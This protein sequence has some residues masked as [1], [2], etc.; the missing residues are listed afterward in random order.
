MGCYQCNKSRANIIRI[1]LEDY[2]MP[3]TKQELQDAINEYKRVIND[4]SSDSGTIAS[5]KK[6]IL[7]LEEELKGFDSSWGSAAVPVVRTREDFD[8]LKQKALEGNPVIQCQVADICADYS[9]SDFYD[10]AEAAHWYEKAAAQGN[11]RAQWLLGLF[12]FQGL[13]GLRQDNEKAEEWLLKSAHSGD[14]DGQYALG[15][16]YSMKPDLVKAEYWLEKAVDG[17]N[18]EARV[19]LDGVRLLL[20]T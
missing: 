16:F 2:K 19:M 8:A 7:I 13:G 6:A 12:Y 3:K 11:T 18:P 17:G 20:R 15:G 5:S 9:R 1:L 14:V 4:P 10:V